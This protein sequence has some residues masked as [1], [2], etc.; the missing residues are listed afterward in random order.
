[1]SKYSEKDLRNLAVGVFKSSPNLQ[2]VYASSAG[3]FYNEHQYAKLDK[4]MKADCLEIKNP[5]F[6]KVAPAAE[7]TEEQ[8]AEREAKEEAKRLKAEQAAQKKADDDAK[9][10]EA[11]AAAEAKKK[12]LAEKKAK[13]AAK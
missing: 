4:D 12:E 10:Q 2:V 3:T 5:A 1:M 7:E 13:A 8:K 6:E 11:A 9:K